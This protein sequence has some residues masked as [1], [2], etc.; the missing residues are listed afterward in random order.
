[1]KPTSAARVFILALA[2]AAVFGFTTPEAHAASATGLPWESSLQTL[3]DSLSGPVAM[4]LSVIS[5]IIFGSM[6][7]FGGEIS[8]FGKSMCMV[9]LVIALVVS[10]QTVLSTL[11]GVSSSVV[12]L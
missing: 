4:S 1:M 7:I 11:F 8:Q 6:L 5:I 2:L 9:A 12:P 3:Q 10:S